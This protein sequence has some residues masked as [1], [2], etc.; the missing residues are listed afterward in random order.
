MGLLNKKKDRA[1]LE[2]VLDETTDVETFKSSTIPDHGASRKYDPY[3]WQV[4]HRRLAWI[5]RLLIVLVVIM[6]AGLVT[7][8]EAIS[9]LA[10]EFEPKLAL[11]RMHDK[12]DRLI[13]I[14]PIREDVP[15]FEVL[16]RQKARRY[17]RLMLEIDRVTQTE[18]FREAFRMT[19]DDYYRRFRKARI[20]SDAV[21]DILNAGITRSI[22]VE[23]VERLESS[24]PYHKFVVDFI[25]TDM[26]GATEIER[27]ELRAY[28]TMTTRGREAAPVDEIE[29]PLGIMVLDMVLKEKRKQ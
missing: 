22:T 10:R 11:V 7:A 25:Q 1:R 8:L 16:L 21:Q 27:K 19:D 15:G 20:E 28:L 2:P 26:Q 18:R 9:D 6:G 12:D 3:S 29:N 17:V 14:E 4:A 13:F 5:T 23:S 24:G